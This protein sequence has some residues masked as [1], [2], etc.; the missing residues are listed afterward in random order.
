MIGLTGKLGSG[1][2]DRESRIE[3]WGSGNQDRSQAKLKLFFLK[4]KNYIK[5]GNQ[6]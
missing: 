3:D 2:E 1:I 6:L 4:N 5:S